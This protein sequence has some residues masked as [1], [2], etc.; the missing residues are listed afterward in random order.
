MVHIGIVDLELRA[1]TAIA[2]FHLVSVRVCH[3]LPRFDHVGSG[4]VDFGE[5]GCTLGFTALI[6]SQVTGAQI[7]SLVEIVLADVELF[8][9]G[10]DPVCI[11]A[12]KHLVVQCI[13]RAS[14]QRLI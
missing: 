6:I 9:A 4:R 13:F 2:I 12:P 5:A 10:W 1:E 11:F 8:E 14:M 3:L 7:G